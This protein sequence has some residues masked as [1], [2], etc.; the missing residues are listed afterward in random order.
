MIDTPTYDPTIVMPQVW[1]S[2]LA[3]FAFGQLAPGQGIAASQVI[4]DRAA[5]ARRRRRQSHRH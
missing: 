3:A 4:A 1:Q 5:S 2:L